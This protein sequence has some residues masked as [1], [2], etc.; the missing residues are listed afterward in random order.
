MASKIFTTS[1]G[2]VSV[3]L[4]GGIHLKINSANN[5]PAELSEEEA[6]ELAGILLKLARAEF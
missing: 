1:G 5:D 6:I 2:E 4:D 3:W